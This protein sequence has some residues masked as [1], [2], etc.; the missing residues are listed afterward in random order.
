MTSYADTSF[1]FSIY[2]SDGNSVAAVAEM[3]SVAVCTLSELTSFEL[4]NAFAGCRFRDEISEE[5]MDR[6][7]GAFHQ[8]ARTGLFNIQPFPPGTF[9]RASALAREHTPRLG[10]RALDVLHVAAA[11]LLG[12]SVFY[13]FDLRQARLARAAGLSVRPRP[14]R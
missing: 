7:L 8:D 11:D 6:S 4:A 5:E 2:A 1:V 10:T 14:R 3:E 9:E 13:T 12:A